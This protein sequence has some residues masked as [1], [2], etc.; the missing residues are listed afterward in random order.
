MSISWTRTLAYAFIPVA[1]ISRVLE[2]LSQSKDCQLLLI[3]PRWPRQMW[4][5]RLLTMVTGAITSSKYTQ[6][7]DS[8]TRG[9]LSSTSD[10]E[11]L[12]PDSLATFFKSYTYAGLSDS[13]VNLAGEAK[14]PSTWRSYNIHLTK[15]FRWCRE[16]QVRPHKASLGVVCD[17]W[18]CCLALPTESH[19]IPYCCRLLYVK[20]GPTT[21]YRVYAH[22]ELVA[23]QRHGR[24]L[25][26]V[27]KG[28]VC[29]GSQVPFRGNHP[30]WCLSQYG[31]ISK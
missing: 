25:A 16:C 1:L 21:S 10:A 11:D 24:G 28:L 8:D 3:T 6:G 26:C 2:K 4:L 20:I 22:T 23:R 31:T 18:L 19:K 13:A 5:P 7:P 17:F 14:R 30:F 12:E 9:A 29:Q 27:V 15:F